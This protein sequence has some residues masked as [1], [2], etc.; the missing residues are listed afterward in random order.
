MNRT[1]PIIHVLVC[2][3]LFS[4]VWGQTD[5]KISGRVVSEA[6]DPLPGANI[7]V[8]GTRLGAAADVDGDYYIVNIPPGIY[9]VQVSM[10]GY[11][12]R[13]VEDVR[14]TSKMTTKVDF[15]LAETVIGMEQV[16]V[17]AFYDPPVQKDQTYKMQ[18]FSE[19][20]L[21]DLPV[22][23]MSQV[24][25]MQ[26]GV[27]RDI[28]TVPVSSR[29]VFGQFATVPSDGFHFRGG[30]TNETLYLFDGIN[31]KDGIWGGFKLNTVG[32]GSFQSLETF[33]GTFGPQFGEAMSGVFNMAT[34]GTIEEEYHIFLKGYTDNLG[35]MEGNQNTR[36]GEFQISGP[37]PII[38]NLSF[39]AAG[40]SF[41]TDG[42]IFGYLYPNYVDSRGSDKSGSP[43]EVP[44]QY[45]DSRY[46]MGKLLWQPLD[47]IKLTA[48]AFSTHATEGVYNHF[49]KYN[50]YGTP[51]VILGDALGYL[52]INHVLN[53]STFYTVTF[54]SYGRDFGSYV[55]DD[56][57]SYLII[58]QYDTNEFSISGEDWVYFKTKFARDEVKI[59]F[60]S[61]LSKTHKLELGFTYDM[62]HTYL[63]RRNPDGFSFIEN[64]DLEPKKYS[65]YVTDKMEF[66]EMGM[67]VNLGFRYDYIDPN[68]EY[69]IEMENPEGDVGAVEARA[70]ASPRI[71]VSYPI[72]DVA[73]FHFGYGHYY[74]FPDFFK[75]YQ[76]MNQNYH[77]YP[78]P[79]V[80]QVS[81][82]I[83]TGDIEEEKTVNYEAGVQIKLTD[84]I[85]ADITGFY[86]KTSNLIGVQVI[87]DI[88]GTRFP[89]FNNINFA[90]VKGIELSLKKRLSDNFQGF[91][92]YTFSQTL[93]SS[94]FLFMRPAD[95]SRTFPADWD[96]PHVLSFNLS[97]KYPGGWGFDIFG[98]ASSG[99]PY[100]FNQ[101]EPNAER[102]PWIGSLDMLIYKEFEMLGWRERIFLQILNVPNRRNVWWVYADSGKPGVDA[103]PA[104]SDDYTND[105]TMWG[106]GQQVILGISVSR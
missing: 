56:S 4:T 3:C 102:A 33:S 76:G 64:Y 27:T 60:S 40:K 18:S 41:A 28:Q 50:P 67:I 84:Y 35:N 93:V 7:I 37:V 15:T 63:E 97:F 36:S 48:G 94:S 66:E 9:N 26:A 22:T 72:T 43:T 47:N 6:G 79:D 99:L 69:V 88:N 31:V 70:Y 104:T 53:P 92:N 96:Q 80:R 10:M 59:D 46:L 55:W 24:V 77:G 87:E 83:A 19:M 95:L 29:P 57:A 13:I 34:K 75:V 38:P 21:R 101:F 82:A 11:D 25:E 103:S 49:F 54:A 62:L 98:S 17:E 61:Q 106:P 100:T 39:V 51:K 105:P 5:G 45:Q 30:R 86:R 74:Q 14:V 65:G 89:A 85:S 52:K 91:L 71:G 81:G 8:E 90:T 16:I 44:M 20:E 78:R 2:C 68:R 58:P 12:S 73:A 42:Y 1:I 32:E 23:D